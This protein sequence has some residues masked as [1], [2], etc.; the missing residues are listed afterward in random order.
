MDEP[1]DDAA[2]VVALE[3][4][5]AEMEAQATARVLHAELR[6]AAVRAGMVDLDGIKLIDTAG[7]SMNAAGELEGGAAL[8]RDLR[9]RKPWLFGGGSSSST[10]AAPP[11]SAARTKLATEMSAEEW[12]AARAELLRRRED[13]GC[14]PELGVPGAAIS[15]M[16][17]RR[18]VCGQRDG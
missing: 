13:G 18:D 10:A 1:A 16:V 15:R 5:L 14:A 8:M 7:L 11:P 6:A 17:R 12:Q 9:T 4:R 2:K 3:A